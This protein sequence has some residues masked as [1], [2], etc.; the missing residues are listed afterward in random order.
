MCIPSY[1]YKAHAEVD[2]P[3]S[4]AYAAVQ[5]H[6]FD[7]YTE[8]LLVKLLTIAYVHDFFPKANMVGKVAEK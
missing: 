6:F 4:L 1:Q 5:L 8:M 3:T 2:W 7:C